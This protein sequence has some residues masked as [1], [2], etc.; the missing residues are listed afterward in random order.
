[1]KMLA[2]K[3]MLTAMITQKDRKFYFPNQTSSQL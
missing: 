1:M 2:F 3:L